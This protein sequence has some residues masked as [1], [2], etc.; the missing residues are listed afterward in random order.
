[1][2]VPRAEEKL[3]VIETEDEV[4]DAFSAYYADANKNV[5]R[6]PV[7]SPELGLAIERP[8]EGVTLDMLWRV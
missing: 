8:K 3:E 2:T 1:M 4:A 7:F 6:E 5:D